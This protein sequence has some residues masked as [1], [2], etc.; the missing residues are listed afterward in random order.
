MCGKTWW[1]WTAVGGQVWGERA[2]ASRLWVAT[3]GTEKS[4]VRECQ[5]LNGWRRKDRDGWCARVRLPQYT[6]LLW[7]KPHTLGLFYFYSR[8][9]LLLYSPSFT[10]PWSWI[11]VWDE[12]V[13]WKHQQWRM[14]TPSS[15]VRRRLWR[16]EGWEMVPD[17]L[18]YSRR[19]FWRYF[20]SLWSYFTKV[21]WT[22]PENN[23][24]S[25][26][27]NGVLSRL[28]RHVGCKEKWARR[29]VL[30]NE[31][32]SCGILVLNLTT[33]SLPQPWVPSRIPT[34]TPT[35]TG[36]KNLPRGKKNRLHELAAPLCSHA[37]AADSAAGTK[38]DMLTASRHWDNSACRWCT[39]S[40]RH[41]S[42][43]RHLHHRPHPPP[44]TCRKVSKVSALVSYD[45]KVNI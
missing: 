35:S 14:S 12:W 18:I 38:S 25:R 34:Q 16:G 30:R 2:R 4:D 31:S 27:W 42:T 19:I 8:S 1:K 11:Q 45:V 13:Y 43:C 33:H 22:V 3:K 9:R 26:I 10:P 39:R 28:S 44:P 6:A 15:S 36:K 29:S 20:T 41:P 21:E 23:V 37:A 17:F 7:K 32:E 40:S 5:Y 24:L